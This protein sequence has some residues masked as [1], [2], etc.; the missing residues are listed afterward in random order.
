MRVLIVDPYYPAVLADLYGAQPQLAQA[1]YDVQWRTIMALSFGT[2]DAYSYH[3]TRLGHEAHE[4][5]PNC[6]FLQ[7]AWARDHAPRLAR[8]PWRVGAQAIL[9]AQTKWFKPDVVYVQSI[10]A[11]RPAVLK[12][13]R[14]PGGLLVGQVASEP[15]QRERVRVY[16]L[17]LTSFPHFVGRLDVPTEVLRIGFDERVLERITD[18]PQHDIVFV[19]QLGG[20]SH[21]TANAVVEAAAHRLPID[22]WGPGAEDWPA[23]SPFRLRHHGTAWG[24]E[25]YRILSGA[26]IALNRHNAAA[27]GYANNMRLFE[28]TGVGTLLLTDQ[29]EGLDELFVPGGELVTYAGGDELVEKARWFLEHSHERS[30]I[31]AAGQTRTLRDHGYRNRMSEL[32]VIL[33]RALR[34]S[35]G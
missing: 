26:R 7:L 33:E 29:L 9:L 23:D 17:L 19:G 21:Q 30:E 1:S 5:V 3:L 18:P 24:L 11:F 14:P 13:L 28:A 2:S 31:A 12:R 10:G 4:V 6:R 25:M 8:L 22:V 15:P 27:G 35:S 34:R 32:A 20:V 16:D